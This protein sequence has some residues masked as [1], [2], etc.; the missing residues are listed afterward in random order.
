MGKGE[1]RANALVLLL[2]AHAAV[3]VQVV[4][5]QDG[6]VGEEDGREALEEELF[7]PVSDVG[8]TH[9]RDVEDVSPDG[10]EQVLA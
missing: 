3:G 1:R 8:G 6:A 5:A 7:L 10:S 4:R 2:V 9:L